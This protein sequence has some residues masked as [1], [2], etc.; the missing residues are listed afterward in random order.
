MFKRNQVE[1]AIGQI[2]EP[3]SA[4]LSSTLRSRIRRLLET[5][6]RFSQS[7]RSTDPGRANFA[8][9][10][11]NMP[12]RGAENWFS[13]YEAFALLTGLRL[14]QHAWPQGFVV[15]LLRRVRPELEKEHTRISTQ[16]S[17][18]L[19][20]QQVIRQRA[21]SGDMAVQNTDPVFLGIISADPN[22]PRGSNPAAIC[23]GQ[24][25]LLDFLRSYGVGRTLTSYELVNSARAL[26]GALA[27]TRPR[28]RG[29]TRE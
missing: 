19:F 2:L 16:G 9:F 13:E 24:E 6:R 8:F 20:D 3:R 7:K 29:R 11:S 17:A 18:G 15:P 14:M 1:Q 12:G 25:R 26:S 28:K 22:G 10:S 21:K 4:K 5:D 23:R 27:E